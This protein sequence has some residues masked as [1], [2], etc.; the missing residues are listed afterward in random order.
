MTGRYITSDPMGLLGGWNTYGYV[1]GNPMRWVDT[2]GLMGGMG[3][4]ESWG[5][6]GE[7]SNDIQQAYHEYTENRTDENLQKWI[8]AR[9]A[10][11]K[12]A[13]DAVR[14]STDAY[15]GSGIKKILKNLLP[16]P[17]KKVPGP[18]FPKEPIHEDN[19]P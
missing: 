14:N 4:I 17:A 7:N 13:A 18:K 11:Q 15:Y 1:D 12:A 8:D 9:S 2:Y 6:L 19:C 3:A 10:R 5:R 16:D